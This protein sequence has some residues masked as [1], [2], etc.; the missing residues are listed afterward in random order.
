MKLNDL[1][2]FYN[3]RT[4]TSGEVM[5]GAKGVERLVSTVR[6]L[7]VGNIFEGTVNSVKNGQ[8]VLALSSGKELLARL[9]ANI[10]IHPGQSMF[11]QV[12]ANDGATVAI[13]PYTVDGQGV[14]LTLMNALKAANL[15]VTDRTL[16]MV[17][18]MMQEQ[19]PIDKN[20]M[21]QMARVLMANPDMKA[22]TLV[23][24]K[25]LDIPITEQMVSQFENYVEDHHAIHDAVDE[26]VRELPKTLGNDSMNLGQ[27]KEFD[28]NFLKILAD[29]MLQDKTIHSDTQSLHGE[30]LG[31]H[32]LQGENLE[33]Q[34][35]SAQAQDINILDGEKTSTGDAF[36]R[37]PMKEK[38][39][40]LATI[41]Q[42]MGDLPVSEDDTAYSIL[43]K[44]ADG[45]K[46][47][48]FLIKRGI[49]NF[50][51]DDA[52]VKFLKDTVEDQLLLKPEEL[53]NENSVQKLYDKLEHKMERLELLLENAQ[54]KDSSMNQTIT[55]I[56]GNL[57]F[58]NE[59]N[60]IYTFV[61]IPMKMTNQNASAQLYVYTNKKD[62]E[63]PEKDLTAFLHLD[64]DHLGATDVSVRM[65]K[66]EVDTK[67]Y[68]ES[69]ES[70]ELVKAYIPELEK[71]LAK[72]GYDC[73]FY[74]EN[75]GKRVDF[76]EDFLK[77]D[78]PSAGQ[79]HRYSFD[80]R[81]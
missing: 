2:N 9:D 34:I 31:S 21:N 45:I 40:L 57:E 49:E 70:Y 13:R 33:S 67:F 11:F 10:S 66:K 77:K 32:P 5:M 58:M 29:G 18:T 7:T 26:F 68:M 30:I 38:E 24:M 75:E 80:M 60:H 76:V 48:S 28:G 63:D 65:H 35:K 14:N 27:L 56:R 44:M 37:L 47:N 39:Q 19:M 54:L 79:L 12:K 23:Q 55:N 50:F 78:A 53:V 61:Q 69:D 4:N 62:L 22:Q 16:N 72:K 74:V 81:A 64:L 51:S 59:M 17:N 41:K 73:K 8:V 42:Y 52:V 46:N 71:K 36:T 15:S 3:N 25:K 6:E 1:T 20:S 43:N